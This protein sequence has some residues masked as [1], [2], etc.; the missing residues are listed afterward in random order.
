MKKAAPKALLEAGKATQ[1]KPGNAG[2]PKGTRPMLGEAFVQALYADFQEH[3]AVAMKEARE[4]KP[5]DYLRVI[6]SLLP[7][8][9]EI[10]R[11][12]EDMSD[13][14]LVNAIELIR[15]SVGEGAGGARS[16]SIEAAGRKPH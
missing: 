13:D 5:A 1:F 2:R 15:A 14:E 9:V 7:K 8:E 10:K 12:L 3:G 11:P 6:A 16:R 4:S